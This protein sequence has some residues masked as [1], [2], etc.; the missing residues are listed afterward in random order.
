[1]KKF[2]LVSCALVLGAAIATDAK[3]DCNGIYLAGRGG[4]VQHKYS[5]KG[6]SVNTDLNTEGLDKNRLM[7]SG[8]LGYRYDYVRAELE[9][10]WRDKSQ[11]SHEIVNGTSADSAQYNFKSY[12]F[13]LNGYWDLAPFHWLSPYIGAG[14]GLTTMKYSDTYSIA[15]EKYSVT[16]GLKGYNPTKFTWS[17]GG[18]LTL[19]VTNRFNIDA[20]YRYYDMGSI[21]EADITAHEI[22]GGLRYVF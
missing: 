22:Y 9:Y 14:I 12:S 4:V 10:V 20:G 16:G 17:V 21:K 13:M 1:M 19:K 11:K 3:A 15:G 6:D 18:G 5:H 8:A 7:L 2:L